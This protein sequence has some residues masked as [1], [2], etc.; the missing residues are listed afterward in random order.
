MGIDLLNE[1]I[2][3]IAEQVYDYLRRRL[4][5]RLLEEVVISVN[6]VDPSNYTLEI[7]V[8]ASANPLLSGLEDIINGAVEFGFKIADYL[9]E[10][11]KRGELD[12]LQP[13]EIER[14]AREYA[15]SLRDN[16]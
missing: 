12:G 16:A 3:A 8:D 11:F 2:N 14:I 5:E 6:L 7:S 4:P 10:R 15:R 9:M 13:G 1:I